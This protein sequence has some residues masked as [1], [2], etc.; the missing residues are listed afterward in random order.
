MFKQMQKYGTNFT[1]D[2]YWNDLVS[3]ICQLNMFSEVPVDC[4][5]KVINSKEI[6]KWQI[7]RILSSFLPTFYFWIILSLFSKLHIV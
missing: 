5:V 6:A 7:T 4:I 3:Y 1:G 2:H